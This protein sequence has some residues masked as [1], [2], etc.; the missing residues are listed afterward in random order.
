MRLVTEPSFIRF[1]LLS[2][3][4]FPLNF[5]FINC[6]FSILK[7]FLFFFIAEEDLSLIFGLRFDFRKLKVLRMTERRRPAMPV[8]RRTTAQSL[9]FLR[10]ICIATV[11]L[12]K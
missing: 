11:V 2:L 12:R 10:S 3:F 5:L 1:T 8:R 7:D 6:T 4:V 9:P